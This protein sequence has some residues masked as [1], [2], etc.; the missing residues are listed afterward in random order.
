[1]T[2]IN[3]PDD[4]ELLKDRCYSAIS[5][6]KRA[7]Q[8]TPT[9]KHFL[10]NAK[11][12]QAGRS[13]PPYYLVYFLLVDLLKFKNLG[14]FEKVSWS[15]PI[16]FNG[17][18]FVVEYRKLGVGVFAADLE[19]DEEDA[20][21]IVRLIHKGVKAA[22]VYFEWVASEAVANSK[23]N[24]TN[25][26]PELYGRYKYLLTLYEKESKEAEER[27]DEVHRETKKTEYGEATIIHKPYYQL[28][29]NSNWLAISAIEAFY[30]W[31]EHLFIHLAI[32]SRGLAS[33]ER[34]AEL[35][36]EEWQTKFKSCID[37]KIP[38]QRNILTS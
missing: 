10:F 22:R 7:D 23:L 8:N 36:G 14:Q 17:K 37:I 12:T 3:L 2:K 4:I 15:I 5:P 18:A 31:T 19:K 38:R 25:N 32:V 13:L 33:G 29:Q 30:S 28:K 24:V 1:M 26:C 11:R 9:E 21:E 27:K 20:K 6:V 35:A 16:E 34:V